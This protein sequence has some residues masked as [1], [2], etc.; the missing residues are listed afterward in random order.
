MPKVHQCKASKDY[1]QHG[2]RK[3]DTYYHWAFFRGRKQMSKTPPRRS[4]ITA[5]PTLS[6]AYVAHESFEDSLSDA[7][8]VE[9]VATACEDAVSAFDEVLSDYQESISN[10]EQA[11]QNGCPALE[12]KQEQHDSVETFKE[13]LDNAHTELQSFDLTEHLDEAA[14]RAKWQSDLEALHEGDEDWEIDEEEFEL[15]TEVEWDDL[16]EEEKADALEAALEM[17]RQPDFGL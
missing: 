17:A 9:D 15:P 6:A 5:S 2:I 14:R 10:L 12:E 8:C 3:G 13:E 16:T 4:Q 1:P 7:K 11:F